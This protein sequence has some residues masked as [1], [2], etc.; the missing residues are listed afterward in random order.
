MRRLAIAQLGSAGVVDDKEFARRVAEVAIRLSVPLALRAAASL[1]KDEHH[2]G[3]LLDAAI[4]CETE[5]T[6]QAAD[7]AAYAAYAADAAARAAAYAAD[8]A[9]YAA[10][11]AAARA[12]AYAA[13]AAA[14]YAADAARAAARAAARDKALADFAEAVVQVLIEMK[15]P[16]CEFLSLTE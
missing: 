13:Y 3:A 16:G 7:A 10:A 12:A 6:E 11:Y 1:Q 8:A 5:G 2:K 4:R 14:A 15:A 9:A